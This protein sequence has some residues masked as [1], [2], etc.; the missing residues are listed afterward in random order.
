MEEFL[1]RSIFS[2]VNRPQPLRVYD[3]V[4]PGTTRIHRWQEEFSVTI[5]KVWKDGGEVWVTKRAWAARPE[6][7]W[8]WVERD[9]PLEIWENV[10]SF[11]QPLKT[12]GDSGGGDGFF[13][14]K[15]DEENS[16]Y[17][18]PFAATYEQIINRH[19]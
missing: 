2:E 19:K 8:N 7:E 18:T 10:H 1:G 11:M 3:I 12:D 5:L 14:L 16:R 4:E 15:P 17:L 6:P 13:R 9:D